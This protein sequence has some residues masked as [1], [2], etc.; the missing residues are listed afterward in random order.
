LS[1]KDLSMEFAVG[2]IFFASLLV[3]GTFTILLS[4]ESFFSRK[5]PRDVFFQDVSS[6]SPGD[7]VL[8]RGVRIGRA[9]RIFLE[10]SRVR[11]RLRLDRNLRFYKDYRVEVRYAS[12]LGGRYVAVDLGT[13]GSGELPASEALEG[14]TPPDL[15]NEAA[16]VVQTVREEVD[17]IKTILA[18]DQVVEKFA[19]FADDISA[20][21]AEVRQGQGTLGRLIQDPGLYDQA[22]AT[23]VS[24]KDGGLSLKAATDNLN[25]LL[26]DARAGKG[27]V[28]KLLTDDS[29][30]RDTQGIVA[31]LRAG[32][33]TF[34]KLLTDDSLYRDLQ[35]LTTDLKNVSTRLTQG[36]S[37]LGKLLSDNGELYLSLKNTLG[38]AEETMLSI[39]AGKGTLGKLALDP[40]LYDDARQAVQEVRGAIQDFREQAPVST[41]GSLIF[42]AF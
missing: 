14:R 40:A 39:R 3:L 15:V 36:Q 12:L 16:R 7:N 27:T 38:A 19:R 1:R 6:L 18:R 22:N 26:A 21:S 42:G 41:F 32:K 29:L 13:P 37:S 20:L 2:F 10:G 33:G 30:Y 4:R 34:G 25:G 8:V 23:L 5:V 31:D 9:D 11:V 17:R 24:L 28:G 35:S